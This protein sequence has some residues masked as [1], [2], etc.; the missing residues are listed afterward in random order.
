LKGENNVREIKF[1]AWHKNNNRMC[2]NVTTDLLDRDYLE[3]MQYTGL[4]E[5]R[6]LIGKYERK[7][8]Y[9]GDIIQEDGLDSLYVVKFEA[10]K[11]IAECIKFKGDIFTR[12]DKDL[13]DAIFPVVVGNIYENPELIVT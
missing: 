10:C 6:N 11:F 1:R 8:I 12:H 7:E 3:F 13:G 2:Q 9:E 4:K 5:R